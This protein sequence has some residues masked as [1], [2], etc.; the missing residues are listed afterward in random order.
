MSLREK[1]RKYVWHPF[2]QM[3]TSGDA[4]AIVSG[5]GSLILT[6]TE[7]AISTQLHLGG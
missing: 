7:E 4:L 2:T 3:K 5:K 6:R 1:D